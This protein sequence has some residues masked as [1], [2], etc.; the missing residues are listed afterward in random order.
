MMLQG[1][2]VVVLGFGVL[3][4]MWIV[5]LWGSTYFGPRDFG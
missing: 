1:F 5:V 4:A 2:E 3:A